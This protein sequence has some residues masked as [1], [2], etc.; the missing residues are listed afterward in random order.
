MNKKI[1]QLVQWL[2]LLGLILSLP[3]CM[4]VADS[5]P[6]TT[7]S[8]KGA[9]FKISDPITTLTVQ[10]V[11]KRSQKNVPVTVGQPFVAGDV[12]GGSHLEVITADGQALPTQV[13]W[14]ATNSDGSLRH[15]IIT[16]VLPEMPADGTIRVGLYR[17]PGKA[18]SKK[19]VALPSD[20]NATV[21]LNLDKGGVETASLKEQL[22][23]QGHSQTWLSGPLVESKLVHGP[24]QK[25]SGGAAPHLA[26]RFYIRYYPTADRSRI[27]II[28][29][30]DW[31][32]VPA[33]HNF[34]YGVKLSINDRPVYEKESLTQ[35]VHT[36][37]RKVY[38]VG[39][40]P[41]VYVSHDLAYLKATGAI[42]N[43]DPSLQVPKSTITSWYQR[44]LKSDHGPLGRSL[45]ANPMHKA[46]GR[47]DI[48]PLPT[49]T[50]LRLLT[51]APRLI[52]VDNAINAL[53]GSWPVHYRDK[54]TGQPI[55]LEDY[56]KV[57][58]HPHL[59]TRKSNPLS[60]IHCAGKCSNKLN[61]DWSHEPSF[62]FVPYMLT[63]DYYYLEE[64][65]F[66]AAWNPLRTSPKYRGYNKGLF[67]WTQVRGQAWA[68]R[69]LGQAA[70][71]TPDNAP[72]KKY[73]ERQLENN[74]EYYNQR[75][76]NNPQAD[77]LGFLVWDTHYND[78]RGLAPW[79]DDFFTWAMG[80][81]VDLG[82]DK[83]QPIR[84][85][86]ARF[87]VG[88]MTAP[89]YCWVLGAI[90]TL[91]VRDSRSSPFY[92]TF[93]KAY[94]NSVSDEMLQAPCGS[95]KMASVLGKKYKAGDMSGY[96]WS[97]QGFPANMQPALA[98]A[99]DAGVPDADKAWSVYMHRT[100]KPDYSSY[101]NWDI[102]P[103]DKTP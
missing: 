102:V 69:T 92:K 3:A 6:S 66:W 36:R 39:G 23:K 42:P 76:P 7:G 73:W 31:T 33:P 85:Y 8:A 46:G 53:A 4:G 94:K 80:Y 19:P 89:G 67:K 24:L 27:E 14:K 90:Y 50:V 71:I 96:P 13:N 98:T 17:R 21:R 99:V 1:L 29:E 101:P 74:L 41:Q 55:S 79:Q 5:S 2:F 57:S 88:R 12:P 83:A 65:Q 18:A 95:A 20:L 100:T 84:D 62:G 52:Q 54:M 91:N 82:F 49:W 25:A 60:A 10:S 47:Q 37:W 87:P 70:Y 9:G 38:W 63:G 35:G 58:T 43:Y 103:R 30:N 64:L 40:S 16:F 34:N 61:P 86:K 48:G 81:L 68:L 97:P 15:G 75:Y 32:F 78:Y 93:A 51:G 28:V 11:S 22:R 26:A 44:Y 45:V 59:Q 77:K 72:T 56:P